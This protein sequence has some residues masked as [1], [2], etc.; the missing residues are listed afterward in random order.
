MI[1]FLYEQGRGKPML[2]FVIGALLC[3]LGLAVITEQLYWPV[4]DALYALHLP[5][6]TTAVGVVGF[7][8]FTSGIIIIATKLWPR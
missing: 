6:T 3:A 1:M 7:A 4:A 5:A 2:N 8:A